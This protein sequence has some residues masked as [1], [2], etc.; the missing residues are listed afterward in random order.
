[1][2][3]KCRKKGRPRANPEA[4]TH[5]HTVAQAR[6]APD[7]LEGWQ[8]V[9][10]YSGVLAKRVAHQ[11]N[12]SSEL[13]GENPAWRDYRHYV[14]VFALTANMAHEKRQLARPIV[15][16]EN[17]RIEIA[18]AA[19]N[20]IDQGTAKPTDFEPYIREWWDALLAE[21]RGELHEYDVPP[22]A[23]CALFE[24][25]SATPGYLDT[26]IQTADHVLHSYG[27]AVKPNCL[28]VGLRKAGADEV[29]YTNHSE[30]S[31][32]LNC[33][34]HHKL[35][36]PVLLRNLFRLLFD[37]GD[38]PLTWDDLK[39]LK[40][41]LEEVK[42]TE[43]ARQLGLPLDE[44][45]VR[46]VREDPWVQ[47]YLSLIT[48][49]DLQP[50]ADWLDA[51]ITYSAYL[52]VRMKCFGL[53][54][55]PHLRLCAFPGCAAPAFVEQRMGRICTWPPPIERTKKRPVRYCSHHADQAQNARVYRGRKRA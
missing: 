38:L 26:V 14:E 41:M 12:R 10:R 25:N 49:K 3:S 33:L 4:H 1:M 8:R 55:T 43:A 28:V 19:F 18:A 39:R 32:T 5:D 44:E 23:W 34:I 51:M 54:R 37:F 53:W 15:V 13:D 27:S 46:Q 45:K 31:E 47:L 48:R 22:E 20:Q 52:F 16:D 2:P 11:F 7:S 17:E 35:I 50:F 40:K 21:R 6:P 36:E 29:V 24:A 9:L 42:F 30:A